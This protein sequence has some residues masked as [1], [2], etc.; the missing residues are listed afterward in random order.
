MSGPTASSTGGSL[1]VAPR[2]MGER[3]RVFAESDC[4]PLVAIGTV[5]AHS[6]AALLSSREG[7]IPRAEAIPSEWRT[8]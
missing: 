2:A 7:V 5:S 6:V 1:S 8:D 4:A 3:G